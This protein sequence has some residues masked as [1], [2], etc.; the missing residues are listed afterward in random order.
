MG[1]GE[2]FV[3]GIGRLG[4]DDRRDNAYVLCKGTFERDGVD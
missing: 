2:W 1:P 4:T 3:R